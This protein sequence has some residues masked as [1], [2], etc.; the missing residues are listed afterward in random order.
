MTIAEQPRISAGHIRP[1]IVMSVVILVLG[2]V[3]CSR[4]SSERTA[5]PSGTSSPSPIP[6]FVDGEPCPPA[7]TEL[8]LPSKTGCASAT[9]GRFEETGEQGTFIVYATL[10][11]QSLPVEWHLR[12]SRP[13]GAPLDE[14]VD[15]GSVASYPLVI[16]AE[17]ADGE[18]L[19]EAFVSLLTHS[20]HSG[21]TREL[22]IFGV[23]DGRFFRVKAEG[24]PFLFQVGGVSVTGHGA[25]CRD[26]DL[27]GKPEFV[28][29]YIDGVINDTQ[30]VNDRIYRWRDRS[31]GLLESRRGRMAKAGYSDPL[32]WRYY[33]FRCLGFEPP[34]PYT[35]G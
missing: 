28:V 29:L 3:S 8:G 27:D 30:E 13:S 1:I 2:G 20:Y 9:G 26:V 18:G 21:K 11:D 31:L 7:P 10:D 33:S 25:E 19:D 34:P 12:L 23:E 17:D 5:A 24:E 4:D 35:R 22:G 14:P 15:V 32:L 16:G 6:T